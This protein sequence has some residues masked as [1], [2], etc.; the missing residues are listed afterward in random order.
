[1][2][3]NSTKNIYQKFDWEGIEFPLLLTEI[4]SITNHYN[5]PFN[6]SLEIF[7]DQDYKLI[8][9]LKGITSNHK[10]FEYRE[11]GEIK[12]VGFING[13]TLEAKSNGLTYYINDFGISNLSII[14]FKNNNQIFFEFECQIY[15]HDIEL[16]NENAESNDIICDFFLCSV[17][18]IHFNG[19]TKRVNKPTPFKYRLK[20]DEFEIS[21]DDIRIASSSSWDYSVLNYGEKKI[22]I[23]LVHK[24]LVPKNIDGI[25]IEYRNVTSEYPTENFRKI[26]QE[27][28]SFILGSH[29]QKIGSSSFNFGYKLISAKSNNP[30][31]RI[32][33]KNGNINPIPLKNGG[34][35]GESTVTRITAG[36]GDPASAAGCRTGWQRLGRRH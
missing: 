18:Q 35:D 31:S 14:P 4:N 36:T 2:T 6:S 22:I 8:G 25:L 24:D 30:W 11:N 34:S 20:L 19:M 10:D 13:E 23:Q 17:P 27:Y 28:L 21:N 1:M 32:I 33:S 29:L 3:V 9:V 26:V 15:L 12:K 7:R 16:V 5:I